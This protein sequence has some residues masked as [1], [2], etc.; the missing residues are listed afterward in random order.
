MSLV[1]RHIAALFGGVSQQPQTLRRGDQ[2]EAQVN[3]LSTVQEG[4]K[5]RPP[6]QHIAKVTT[7]DLSTA[8]VHPINRDVSERYVVVVTDGDLK[9]YDAN[10]GVEKT[11]NFPV[12]KTYLDVVG[13]ANATF[14]LV[15]VADYTFVVNKEKVVATQTTPTTTPVNFND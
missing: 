3:A 14:A 11:V 15:S 8:Y 5:K 9:V 1:S 10:T 13:N 12:G 7:A 4:L 2:G 6:F